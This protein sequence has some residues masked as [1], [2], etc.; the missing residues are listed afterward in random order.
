M[1]GFFDLDPLKVLDILI[2]TFISEFLPWQNHL[3]LLNL[4]SFPSTPIVGILEFKLA[5]VYAG[6]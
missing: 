6:Y 2:E 4:F 1:I 5:N 3:K